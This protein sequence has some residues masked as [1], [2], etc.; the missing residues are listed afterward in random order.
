MSSIE[1][2]LAPGVQGR[3]QKISSI[4]AQLRAL[5]MHF[6]GERRKPDAQKDPHYLDQRTGLLDIRRILSSAQHHH[7]KAWRRRVY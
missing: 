1:M 7:R 4:D 6:P 2:N 5:N 3:R